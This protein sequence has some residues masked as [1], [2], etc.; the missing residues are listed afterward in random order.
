MN[1]VDVLCVSTAIMKRHYK[2]LAIFC[3]SLCWWLLF[4]FL[5][6]LSASITFLKVSFHSY[7]LMI[8]R[9]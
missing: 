7:V 3:C 2:S 5:H 4:Q 1:S 6:I 8:L 9:P